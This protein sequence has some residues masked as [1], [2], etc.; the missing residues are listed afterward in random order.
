MVVH[1][2]ARERGRAL[3][4]TGPRP[5]VV[6]IVGRFPGISARRLARVLHLHPSSLTGMLRRL[7]RR[8]LFGRRRE[9]RDSRRAVLGLSAAGRRLDVDTPGAIESDVKGIL[10][11]LPRPGVLATA[12]VPAAVA[13][14]GTPRNGANE[15][16]RI[17]R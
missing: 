8:G 5:V 15:R 7:D 11:R 1:S 9:P 10:G 14:Q 17:L 4:L 3:G 12:R 13:E 6:C 2:T 16:R